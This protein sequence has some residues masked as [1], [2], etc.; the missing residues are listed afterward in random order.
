LTIKQNSIPHFNTSSTNLANAEPRM[1]QPSIMQVAELNIESFDLL[2]YYVCV[3]LDSLAAAS[4]FQSP[5][6]FFQG[7]GI[8]CIMRELHN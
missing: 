1:A 8:S 7:T 4:F 3:K 2:G 6:G 5:L